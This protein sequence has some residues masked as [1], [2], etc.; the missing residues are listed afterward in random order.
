MDKI[1]GKNTSKNLSDKYSQV[2]LD[3][4]KWHAKQDLK[5]ASKKATQKNQ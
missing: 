3:H 2:S 1:I 4:G 5:N